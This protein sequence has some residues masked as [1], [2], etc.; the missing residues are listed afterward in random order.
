MTTTKAVT[1][2]WD[3]ERWTT[4]DGQ[5]CN[6]DHCAMRGRCPH[7]VQHGAQV[8]TCPS[9]IRRTR[10]DLAAI[11]ELYA[12]MAY[13]ARIDGIESEAMNLL[14]PAAAPEQYAERRARLSALYERQGWCEWPRPEAFRSDDPHHP[15]AVL[16]RWRLALEDTGWLGYDD[17]LVTVATAADMLDGALSGGFP[18]SDE[19]EEFTREIAACRTHL[20]QVDHASRTPDLGRPCPSCATTYGPGRPAPRL[21]KRYASH[22]G[23]GPGQRC[24]RKDCAICAG[25][26]DAWHC[27][28]FPELHAWTDG[29]YR[30][31]VDADYVEHATALT[32]DRLRDRF[33]VKPGTIRAWAMRGKVRKHGLDHL[34]RQLYDVADVQRNAPIGEPA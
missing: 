27:P 32:A 5:G 15:Y 7:H 9:C 3:G 20:E 33:G 12:L 1:C 26:H 10:K 13:D 24:E 21:Q 4:S 6:E 8:F 29:D 34:G 16:G 17:R 30:A 2:S 22:P 23:Y 19:W 25:T 14:G 28:D 18:H 11:V 31:K